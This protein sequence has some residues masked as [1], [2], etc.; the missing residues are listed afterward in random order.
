MSESKYELKP[1]RYFRAE[2]DLQDW[3]ENNEELF[4]DI[5]RSIVKGKDI[6]LYQREAVMNFIDVPYNQKRVDFWFKGD[7]MEILVETKNPR[8]TTDD[9][10][11][12]LEYM[13]LV[14]QQKQATYNSASK[15]KKKQLDKHKIIGVLVAPHITSHLARTTHFMRNVYSLDTSQWKYSGRQ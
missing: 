10:R 14:E 15:E 6:Y 8:A 7:N 13:D 12:I 2:K 3:I 9:L 11:Q 4:C 5:L 1:Q